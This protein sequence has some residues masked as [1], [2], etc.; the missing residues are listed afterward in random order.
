MAFD[1]GCQRARSDNGIAAVPQSLQGCV[2]NAIGH[3]AELG[4]HGECSAPL[5]LSNSTLWMYRKTPSC[6]AENGNQFVTVRRIAAALLA[7]ISN[8]DCPDSDNCQPRL[9]LI[10]KASDGCLVGHTRTFLLSLLNNPI[11]NLI[12]PQPSS[13]ERSSVYLP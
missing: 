9:L 2:R 4:C 13:F 5:S 1:Y 12:T 7:Y 10:H 11:P 8:A 3:E 6:C